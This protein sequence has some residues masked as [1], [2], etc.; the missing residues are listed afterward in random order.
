MAYDEYTG[1][2]PLEDPGGM[3]STRDS[4]RPGSASRR[5]GGK[6]RGLFLMF[7]LLLLAAGI[8]LMAADMKR[9]LRH[10]VCRCEGGRMIE[11][12]VVPDQEKIERASSGI[13]A[14]AETFPEI[15]QYMMLVPSAACIQSEYLPENTDLRDQA[16]DLTAIR[17]SM[18]DSLDWID[19]I[20]VFREHS[21]EKIYYATDVYLTG[22][23]SRYARD[24]ALS[25]MGADKPEG[26]DVCY[27][28]SDIFCGRLA[29]DR[30]PLQRLLGTGKE[31][32]EIYVPEG[33]A[34]YYRIDDATGKWYGSLYDSAAAESRQPFNVFFG[35]ERPLT[36][37]RTEAVNGEILLV[38][39]D[40]VADSVVPGFVSSFEKIILVHPTKST[41]TIQ[42]LISE[43]QPTKI[44]YLYGANMFMNDRALLR[45]LGK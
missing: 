16:A 34:A 2:E 22:W 6:K 26:H 5:R 29:D 18:G 1:R 35:G 37:I 11:M 27:L 33:E 38:I 14:L 23:G 17:G 39:G 25:G 4:R 41:K 44:L 15:Q 21:G 3:E 28:L 43:Y 19:L 20:R 32:L 24:A 8:F 7:C 10:G 12:P 42:N 45:T 36:E 9:D 31:R 40:R 13:K 30:K